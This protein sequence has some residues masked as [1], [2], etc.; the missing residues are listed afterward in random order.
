MLLCYLE[1]AFLSL[2]G[3]VERKI[4]SKYTKKNKQMNE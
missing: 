1:I 3:A 4:Q 2:T